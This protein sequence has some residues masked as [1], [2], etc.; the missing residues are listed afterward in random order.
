M[1][2]KAQLPPQPSIGELEEGKFVEVITPE[3]MVSGRITHLDGMKMVVTWNCLQV[4]KLN[5]R[6]DEIFMTREEHILL[7]RVLRYTILS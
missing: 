4:G 3:G 1:P 5:G 7:D 2:E 6:V